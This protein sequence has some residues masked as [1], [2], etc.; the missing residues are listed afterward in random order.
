[1]IFFK[2]IEIV[3]LCFSLDLYLF[4]YLSVLE[5]FL[6]EYNEKSAFIIFFNH[7]ESYKLF[8]SLVFL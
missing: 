7:K 6:W 5:Q 4:Q 8:L 1:M 3:A 2:F